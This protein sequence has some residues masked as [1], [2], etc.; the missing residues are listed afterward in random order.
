[1]RSRKHTSKNIIILA[2][3]KL[4]AVG[5]HVSVTFFHLLIDFFNPRR[6]RGSKNKL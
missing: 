3:V 4:K 1:M 5:F 6:E 2:T